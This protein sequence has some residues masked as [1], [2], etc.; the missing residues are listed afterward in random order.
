MHCTLQPDAIQQR[1]PSVSASNFGYSPSPNIGPTNAD[2][3]SKL[4]GGW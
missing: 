4:E 2:G 1:I 3:D